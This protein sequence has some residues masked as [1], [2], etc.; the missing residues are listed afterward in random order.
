MRRVKVR[1]LHDDVTV[2]LGRNKPGLTED[3]IRL[4]VAENPSLDEGMRAHAIAEVHRHL[5]DIAT[6]QLGFSSLNRMLTL[7]KKVASGSRDWNNQTV[8]TAGSPAKELTLRQRMELGVPMAE[9][10]T[11]IMM[12]QQV[13]DEVIAPL[14]AAHNRKP[15]AC[16][17]WK[18]VGPGDM[19]DALRKQMLDPSK[20]GGEVELASDTSSQLGAVD[21]YESEREDD[22]LCD[23]DKDE[24]KE[25][26]SDSSSDTRRKSKDPQDKA[27]AAL[28]KFGA[29]SRERADD[30]GEQEKKLLLESR[31]ARMLIFGVPR[32]IPGAR[33][34][35]WR[36]GYDEKYLFSLV[37][38]N[39]PEEPDASTGPPRGP[40][41]LQ[42][43][44]T[45]DVLI[46]DVGD[47][48]YRAKFSKQGL[49]IMLSPSEWNDDDE[50][51][52]CVG[53]NPLC[54]EGPF[55]MVQSEMQ[56]GV[57]VTKDELILPACLPPRLLRNL[58]NYYDGVPDNG[59]CQFNRGMKEWAVK[60]RDPGLKLPQ[61]QYARRPDRRE[62]SVVEG[63]D[64]PAF[65]PAVGTSHGNYVVLDEEKAA[66]MTDDYTLA[67]Y[68]IQHDSRDSNE[69]IASEVKKIRSALAARQNIV[70]RNNEPITVEQVNEINLHVIKEC[71]RTSDSEALANGGRVWQDDET[72]HGES[73]ADSL[74]R[75]SK[76]TSEH[77]RR[78]YDNK[79]HQFQRKGGKKPIPPQVDRDGWLAGKVKA[80]DKYVP[81]LPSGGRDTLQQYGCRG[82]GTCANRFGDEFGLSHCPF[83][84]LQ[85]ED[86]T[87]DEALTMLAKAK[88]RQKVA[89][90]LESER[91]YEWEW[92]TPAAMGFMC[93]PGG[94]KAFNDLDTMEACDFGK[95][96]RNL[97]TQLVYKRSFKKLP[98]SSRFDWTPSRWWFECICCIAANESKM[99]WIE[100]YCPEAT[101][102]VARH[103][104][105]SYCY[106]DYAAVKVHCAQPKHLENLAYLMEVLGY[107][108]EGRVEPVWTEMQLTVLAAAISP[109]LVRPPVIANALC[110]MGR[111]AVWSG[112]VNCEVTRGFWGLAWIMHNDYPLGYPT[113]RETEEV[114]RFLDDHKN[115]LEEFG[116]R[117]ALVQQVA[118][119]NAQMLQNVHYQITR[120]TPAGT[121]EVLGLRHFMDVVTYGEFGFERTPA[122]NDEGWMHP[123]PQDWEVFRKWQKRMTALRTDWVKQKTIDFDEV[124]KADTAL[125]L[126]Y[127]KHKMHNMARKGEKPEQTH[128]RLWTKHKQELKPYFDEIMVRWKVQ[129]LPSGGNT[130][131]REGDDAANAE[132][133]K[134][135]FEIARARK[136]AIRGVTAKEPHKGFIYWLDD[137]DKENRKQ[138]A[139]GLWNWNG[140]KR[141]PFYGGQWHYDDLTKGFHYTTAEDVDKMFAGRKARLEQHSDEARRRA[142]GDKPQTDRRTHKPAHERR[143]REDER[144][145]EERAA[146]RSRSDR[147]RE[148]RGPEKR[149]EKEKD[150]PAED[151]ASIPERASSAGEF[152]ERELRKQ[153]KAIAKDIESRQR[154]VDRARSAEEKQKRKLDDVHAEQAFVQQ[155]MQML[156]KGEDEE[157]AAYYLRLQRASQSFEQFK[158][159][160]QEQPRQDFR[161]EGSDV[162]SLIGRDLR[163]IA[164][165]PESDY[166]ELPSG[167]SGPLRPTLAAVRESDRPASMPGRPKEKQTPAEIRQWGKNPEEEERSA[168]PP[169]Y[170]VGRLKPG[171]LSEE[172]P[173][174]GPPSAA[175]GRKKDPPSAGPA[176]AA[177][178][179]DELPPPQKAPKPRGRAPAP[180]SMFQQFD[181]AAM[182][183]YDSGKLREVF[184][185]LNSCGAGSSGSHNLSFATYTE[186]PLMR[187]QQ[188]K[189]QMSDDTG[190]DRMKDAVNRALDGADAKFQGADAPGPI[191]RLHFAMIP[192]NRNRQGYRGEI[193]VVWEN[194]H[195]HGIPR[196]PFTEVRCPK[197]TIGTLKSRKGEPLYQADERE[198][199]KRM[200]LGFITA[201]CLEL[202]CLLCNG[203]VFDRNGQPYE[204]WKD[205]DAWWIFKT[206][207]CSW[208]HQT[209]ALQ[210]SIIQKDALV[211]GKG[212]YVANKGDPV[213]QRNDMEFWQQADQLTWSL[214]GD[215]FFSLSVPDLITTRTS[216]FDCS[217]TIEHWNT[218]FLQ[219]TRYLPWYTAGAEEFLRI[220]IHPLGERVVKKMIQDDKYVRSFKNRLL[221][222]TRYVKNAVS[223]VD[224]YRSGGQMD[225]R[226]INMGSM[227]DDLERIFRLRRNEES[228]DLWPKTASSEVSDFL[229][230]TWK[231]QGVKGAW[232]Q[233]IA[234]AALEIGDKHSERC[235]QITI[236]TTFH[237]SQGTTADSRVPSAASR[238]DTDEQAEETQ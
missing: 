161:E 133:E 169:D 14:A 227:R 65:K 131:V 184:N 46:P 8:R 57:V 97:V 110:P 40:K 168:I 126:F 67:V 108:N 34:N 116:Q 201:N 76:Q 50:G 117:M 74:G 51:R 149:D 144:K 181:L 154:G 164:V 19:C 197:R 60:G 42:I 109:F 80:C 222:F 100:G 151:A 207:I 63:G 48:Q 233:E 47:E 105:E 10:L 91:T 17:G 44:G 218:Y 158:R 134:T 85:P 9:H 22:D 77:Q 194:I 141:D 61:V 196:D 159:P 212:N 210:L 72:P 183:K 232:Q 124:I 166:S 111:R 182:E 112:L 15:I 121:L 119:M 1:E 118:E 180:K 59:Q 87:P 89:A 177:N 191:F 208:E 29:S 95:G 13:K 12:S 16:K 64:T 153:R 138:G 172:K 53:D 220:L 86:I 223:S 179:R 123:H 54:A 145:P 236:G 219:T 128:E 81:L 27:E 35:M 185:Q 132:V 78:A 203:L 90:D 129:C 56:P 70:L 36:H 199:E 148:D 209:R 170:R 26:S 122:K 189:I 30:I 3:M 92:P 230:T 162:D 237:Y 146:D 139:D 39:N 152:D 5:S 79:Y 103:W 113:P 193:S 213:R 115:F 238:R 130:A 229:H 38:F 107:E 226:K 136:V 102:P 114:N 163:G 6:Q 174:E 21:L 33:E 69:R 206:H 99:K 216:V 214:N 215:K 178:Q 84:H 68:T 186:D 165:G 225:E 28:E 96:M 127:A 176:E 140:E 23:S 62:D 18:S 73:D 55:H 156:P 224:L 221:D 147:R 82:G 11:M 83:Y 7:E 2:K 142:I 135:V 143:G 66:V 202:R 125:S 20:G 104:R 217:V 75:N 137:A 234:E 24:K 71:Q 41:R 4:A 93:D 160:R 167:I 211:S 45:L 88:A 43:R 58:K 198:N 175:A 204:C 94:P 171:R 49:T 32:W 235:Q 37:P 157:E 190:G 231:K 52:K 25:S 155:L 98:G 187:G 101:C 200:N 150:K 188:L 120:P 192:R 173:R 31:A 106:I 228:I 205:I 195:R